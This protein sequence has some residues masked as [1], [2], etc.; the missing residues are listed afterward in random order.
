MD[1]V[2]LEPCKRVNSLELGEDWATVGEMTSSRPQMS[3]GNILE[4]DLD[5]DLNCSASYTCTWY[6]S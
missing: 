2:G 3:M 4:L 6:E 5:G 1:G